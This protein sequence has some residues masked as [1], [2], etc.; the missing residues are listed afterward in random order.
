MPRKSTAKSHGTS[1]PV[2]WPVCRSQLRTCTTWRASRPLP[3]PRFSAKDSPAAERD[4]TVVARLKAAGGVLVGANNMDEFAYGFTTQNAHY[5][6][7][8][9]PHDLARSAGGSSGGSAA[10]VAAGI[11][12]LSLW[13]R[14]QRIDPGSGQLL[15]HFR[16]EALHIPAGCRGS[17]VYPFVDDP[18]PCRAVRAIGARPGPCLRS[19]AGIGRGAIRISPGTAG[20]ADIAGVGG[21]S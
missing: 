7:T 5:G 4:A 14:H 3:A 18:R 9:N 13:H 11:V 17:G 6:D 10:A 20:R 12:P 19:D 15:R 21:Y 16:A 1:I 8:H 2:P